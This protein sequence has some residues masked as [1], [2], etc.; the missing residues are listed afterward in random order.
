LQKVE[1]IASGSWSECD[2]ASAVRVLTTLVQAEGIVQKDI[3][4][5]NFGRADGSIFAFDFED[6]EIVHDEKLRKKYINQLKRV[7]STF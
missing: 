1:E 2:K 5:Q 3:S 6:I 4:A 7:V